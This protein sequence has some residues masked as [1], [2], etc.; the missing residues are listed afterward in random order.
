AS[1]E[2]ARNGGGPSMIEAYTYRHYEHVGPYYDHERGRTYRSKT[3]VDWWMDQCDPIKLSA[4]KLLSEGVAQSDLDA[5][6]AEIQAELEAAAECAKA[7]PFPEK[8][9]LLE[10]VW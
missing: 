9:S 6:G 5:M 2:S 8:S 1:I 7:A 4:A 3:D 10:N